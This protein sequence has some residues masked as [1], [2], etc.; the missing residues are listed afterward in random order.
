MGSR[1]AFDGDAIV[2]P[3]LQNALARLD[4]AI[5]QIRDHVSSVAMDDAIPSIDWANHVHDHWGD[6]SA[7]A[8]KLMEQL[9]AHNSGMIADQAA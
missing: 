3:H 7:V 9:S 6:G 8:A 4:D 5:D 1:V 2:F